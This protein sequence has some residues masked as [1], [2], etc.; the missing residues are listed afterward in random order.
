MRQMRNETRN[1]ITIHSNIG[2]QICSLTDKIFNTMVLNNISDFVILNVY[3]NSVRADIV[4]RL[5]NVNEYRNAVSV[6]VVDRL[7]ALLS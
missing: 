4:D 2:D 3:R 6:D 5:R 7:R 1:I